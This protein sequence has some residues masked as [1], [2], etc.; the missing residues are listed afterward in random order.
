MTPFRKSVGE[1]KNILLEYQDEFFFSKYTVMICVKKIG[2]RHNLHF[3]ITI[4][5][6]SMT[7]IHY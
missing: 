4:K 7:S 2:I 5:L 1:I 3:G 6:Q